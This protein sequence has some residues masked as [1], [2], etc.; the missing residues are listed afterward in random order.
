MAIRHTYRSIGGKMKTATL[1]PIRA[2][3][4]HCGE[5]VQSL[6]AREIE[7]CLG[8][9]CALFPFRLGD[10]HTVSEEQRERLR[11]QGKEQ[12]QRATGERP[13]PPW[14]LLESTRA[15]SRGE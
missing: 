9:I 14:Q 6:L 2:I 8:E 13:T 10:A 12:A 1:T 5:C 3:R 15:P 4:E 11:E 7:D